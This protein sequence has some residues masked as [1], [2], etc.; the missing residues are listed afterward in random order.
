MYLL[1]LSGEGTGLVTKTTVTIG[2]DG[3]A[4]AESFIE[5]FDMGKDVQEKWKRTR[6][7]RDRR[8][9]GP[10]AKTQSQH[11]RNQEKNGMHVQQN[12]VP[13]APPLNQGATAYYGKIQY[14]VMLVTFT[15]VI[16]I[17][18]K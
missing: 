6:K 12:L 3:Q 2:E 14:I 9:T 7:S 15:I 16:T 17:W 5:T 4:H 10:Q 13:S 11:D 18:G 8:S 1:I